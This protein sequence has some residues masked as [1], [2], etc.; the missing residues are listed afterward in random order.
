[1]ER[2]KT[3]LTKIKYTQDEINHLLSHMVSYDIQVSAKEINDDDSSKIEEVLNVSFIF[4]DGIGIP[5]LLKIKLLSAKYKKINFSYSITNP[6]DINR[7]L[8]HFLKQKGLEMLT[9]TIQSQQIEF[10]NKIQIKYFAE[11]DLNS[12]LKIN[13]E[14]CDFIKE[15]LNIDNFEIDYVYSDEVEKHKQELAN[16]K[17]VM[18]TVSTEHQIIDKPKYSGDKS[19][20]MCIKLSDLNPNIKFCK[21]RGYVFSV[22]LVDLNKKYDLLKIGIFDETNCFFLKK[23]YKKEDDKKLFQEVVVNDLIEA[24]IMVEIDKFDFNH[25]LSALIRSVKVISH[26]VR[27]DNY[28]DKRVELIVHSKMSAYDGI[29]ELSELKEQLQEFGYKRFAITDRSNVQNFPSVEKTFKGSGINPIYGVEF[30]ITNK[31]NIGVLN[32]P[33]KDQPLDKLPMVIFDLETSG[34]N[35]NLDDI[36]EF[37]AVKINEDK[38]TEKIDFFLKPKKPVSDFTTELTSI[39]NEMLDNEGISQ[40]EGM[41]KIVD[42][43]KGSTLI[44]HNGVSFDFK[45]LNTKLVSYGYKPLDNLMID[46]LFISRAVNDMMSHT[47]GKMCNKYKIGYDV[48]AAHRADYDAQVLYECYLSMLHQLKNLDNDQEIDSVHKL[49]ALIG[50]S[51]KNSKAARGYIVN[52]Y[53]KNQK[54]LR[55]L[56]ELVSIAH[57]KNLVSK[58][59][60]HWKD[61]EGLRENLLIANNPLES[62]LIVSLL[63]DTY[64]ESYEKCAKYDFLLIPSPELFRH[65]IS[66]NQYSVEDIKLIINKLIDL[67]NK[68]KKLMCATSDAYYLAKSDEQFHEVFLRIPGLNKRP[69]RFSKYKASPSMYFRNTDELFE[70]YQFVKGIDLKQLIVTNTQEVANM[71]DENIIITRK[72]LYPPI[73]DGVNDKLKNEVYLNAHK[74]YGDTLPKQVTDELNKELESI[75]GNNYSVVYWVSHLLVEKSI[76]EGYMVGSRGSVGSS[77]V[78][79]FLNITDVNPLPPHYLCKKCKYSNFDLDKDVMDGFDL[80]PINCPNCNELMYGEGHNI[81]FETFLGFKCDKVPDID[82]NFS[83]VC[84]GHAHDFIKEM[85]GED[86]AFRAGTIGTIAEKTSYANAKEY[87]NRKN[88]Q[89]YNSATLKRYSLKTVDVKRTTGQHPGGVIVVPADMS[90]YD[91]C[92]IN[93]PADDSSGGWLTTHFAFE[94]IHDNLLKFD[95]LGHDNPTILKILKDLT[96]I[97]PKDIPVHDNKVM[98]VFTDIKTLGIE[99]ADIFNETTGALSLPEFGTK[100]VRE[101]LKSANPKSFSDLI[102]ISGLSHGTDVWIDNAQKLISEGKLLEDVIACRDD[103]MVY[104][105]KNGIDPLVSFQVMEDVRKGKKIKPEQEKILRDNKIPDWYIESANK[106][107]YMFPKAHATA[108]VL[109]A[110]MFAWYKLYYPLQYY[111]AY[112]SIRAEVFDVATMSGTISNLKDRILSIK[113]RMNSKT[114]ASSVTT[115]EKDLLPLYEVALEARLRGIKINNISI[116]ESLADE[117]KIDK[118]TNSI[119]C[120]FITIDGLGDVAAKS[121]VEAR[122]EKRFSS[123]QDIVSRTKVTKKHIESMKELKILDELNES[124]QLTLF[125]F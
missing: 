3:L 114:D 6:I 53:V 86:K 72:E 65:E 82:L 125:N 45:F 117:F 92:P 17:F 123:I 64:E 24:S 36:I 109:H 51:Q 77:L 54:G 96:G 2:L 40:E 49:D 99:P 74:T 12:F 10:S 43:I 103:I 66:D 22:E 78:A 48:D 9:L 1:M 107:K 30:E 93:Y 50:N 76:S 19:D 58:P 69:H 75:I 28:E 79:T 21:V 32:L 112:F 16:K 27:R 7:Y 110:W 44:A 122:K 111:A 68:Q 25:E 13:N 41:K 71:I 95:I 87:F 108:Y 11:N 26:L 84:Q 38:T 89:N 91:F 70:E 121:I 20:L 115:K 73:I 113:T 98:S 34:L 102:R 106:I 14:M 35:P 55:D 47:L 33:K 124:D 5:S 61:F 120:P 105:I 90:I 101:M 4:D 57:T 60:L 52:A 81:P 104:L 119:L 42:F 88:I 46:T 80:E 85:F 8:I 97:D 62:D 23:V 59:V 94:N 67:G 15:I 83:G 100:F 37:G 39:T 31:H 56:F 18:P 116:E 118:D 29:I 63:N